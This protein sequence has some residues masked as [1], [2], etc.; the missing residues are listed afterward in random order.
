MRMFNFR[1]G[2]TKE[3]EGP[4]E[5][6]SST[7]IDGP[8]EGKS[9][10]VHWDAIRNNYYGQMGWDVETGRPLPETLR[11]LGLEHLVKDLSV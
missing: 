5:R 10:R 1:H 8:A 3:V 6:Y 7:P 11:K 9:I 4:S 2:L